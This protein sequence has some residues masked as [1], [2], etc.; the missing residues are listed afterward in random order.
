[1]VNANRGGDLN[2]C[3]LDRQRRV[4]GELFFLVD[5]YRGGLGGDARGG[6]V[7]VDAPADVLGV[8][9]AAVAPPRVLLFARIE[10]A[11]HVDITDFVEDARHPFAL[12]R[13]E[14]GILLVA[15]PVLQVD[16]LVGDVPVAADDHFVPLGVKGLQVRQ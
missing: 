9:L 4:V 14:A 10:A 7:V 5:R 8:G 13:Q 6:D 1:M 2:A 3:V 11:V 12:L 16:F 15:L